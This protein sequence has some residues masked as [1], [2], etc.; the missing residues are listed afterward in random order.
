[1]GGI[2]VEAGR[3]GG[4]AVGKLGFSS[5][6]FESLVRG[7]G[8]MI[9]VGVFVGVRVTVAVGVGN[10]EVIVGICEAVAVGTVAVGNGPSSAPAVIAMAVFVLLALFSL[11]ALPRMGFPKTMAYTA[12]IRPRHKTI[13]TRI[14]MGIR[15]FPD[16]FKFTRSVLLS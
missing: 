8:D 6:E 7:V 13:C 12:T 1:M 15:F 5:L 2:V 9:G 14:C 4:A 10:V 16:K 11:S 3:V